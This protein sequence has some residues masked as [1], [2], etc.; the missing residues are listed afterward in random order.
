MTGRSE[1]T[2][3][4]GVWNSLE[5]VLFRGLDL[6]LAGHSFRQKGRGQKA[7]RTKR[8][9]GGRDK[10]ERV[11]TCDISGT[12]NVLNYTFFL[13]VFLG[14]R[15][16]IGDVRV[17]R[18]TQKGGHWL[19]RQRLPHVWTYTQLFLTLL[20]AC[21]QLKR[22]SGKDIKGEMIVRIKTRSGKS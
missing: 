12:K 22:Q 10:S 21:Q 5:T 4:I 8:K 9:K 13:K 11:V 7:K 20:C 16:F 6:N 17:E 15:A 3:S 14:P 18:G 19:T 1:L 2:Y